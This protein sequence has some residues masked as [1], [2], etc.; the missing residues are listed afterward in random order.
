M[1]LRIPVAPRG[2]MPQPHHSREPQDIAIFLQIPEPQLENLRDL[3]PPIRDSFKLGNLTFAPKKEEEGASWSCWLCQFSQGMRRFNLSRESNCVYR[4]A[5]MI[6]VLFLFYVFS[7]LVIAYKSQI[8]FFFLNRRV[9]DGFPAMFPKSRQCH[10]WIPWL[11]CISFCC[12]EIEP[13]KLQQCHYGAN[14][15]DQVF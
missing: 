5:D 1:E 13:D 7:M 8:V 12:Q 6:Q 15:R 3:W 10:T 4:Y 11:S 2:S 14:S 9:F